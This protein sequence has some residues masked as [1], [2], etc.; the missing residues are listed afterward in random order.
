MQIFRQRIHVVLWTDHVRWQHEG[1]RIA[2]NGTPLFGDS[3]GH[4]RGSVGD[5]VS[6]PERVRET[7]DHRQNDERRG[8][9][10]TFTRPDMRRHMGFQRVLTNPKRIRAPS[11]RGVW[12]FAKVELMEYECMEKPVS[13]PHGAM[14]ACSSRT[15]R[16]A[17]SRQS[18]KGRNSTDKRRS[19]G[20]VTTRDYK[21]NDCDCNL[22]SA[23][24]VRSRAGTTVRLTSGTWR[25]KTSER[26]DDQVRG[27][28]RQTNADS[29]S[30]QNSRRTKDDRRTL[31]T[32]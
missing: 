21:G 25:R 23:G 20:V 24:R 3:R 29:P 10:M 9:R 2:R 11:Q 27:V 17:S 18:G 30:P 16:R 12:C 19:T 13:P 7:G 4:G 8:I 28:V 5:S 6:E 1:S 22:K 14:K 32:L 31:N 15:T 26:K